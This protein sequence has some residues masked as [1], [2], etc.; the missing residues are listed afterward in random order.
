MVSP[1]AEAIGVYL[2]WGGGSVKG[3]RRRLKN[4]KYP[5]MISEF[6]HKIV[7]RLDPK[8]ASKNEIMV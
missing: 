8:G 6:G 3:D 2:S 7:T 1:F 4:I 5:R